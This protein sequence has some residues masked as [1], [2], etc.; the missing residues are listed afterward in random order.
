MRVEDLFVANLI[1]VSNVKIESS[2]E[3][4]VFHTYKKVEINKYLI[5]KRQKNKNDNERKYIYHTINPGLKMYTL[6]ETCNTGYLQD[7]FYINEIFPLKEFYNEKNI[8]LKDCKKLQKLIKEKLEN[9]EDEK[10]I[11]DLNKFL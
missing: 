6:K 9:S 2:T 1:H 11:D 8:T 7:G 3:Y 10:D 5:F 4:Q